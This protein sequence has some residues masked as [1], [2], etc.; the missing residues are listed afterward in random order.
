[1]A[2]YHAKHK[3]R[4]EDYAEYYATGRWDG[5]WGRR[6]DRRERRGVARLLGRLSP[7]ASILDVPCG[8]GRFLE[9]LLSGGGDGRR[10]FQSDIAHEMVARAREAAAG[11]ARG[12]FVGDAERLPVADASVDLVCTVRLL[13]HVADP[14]V[15][16]GILREAARVS[17]RFVLASYFDRFSLQALRR[18]V[19]SR[20]GGRPS[21]R[22]AIRRSEFLEDARRAG[23]RAVATWGSAPL[24]SEQR[25]VVLER[26]RSDGGG[27]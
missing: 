3:Y 7:L 24:V 14:V 23:L 21:R 27:A 8:A 12:Q 25:F 19:R 10:V 20:L 2:D 17:R 18:R 1:M 4:G 5:V 16:V 15:R 11:R 26:V 6:V 13:H 9:A 22:V